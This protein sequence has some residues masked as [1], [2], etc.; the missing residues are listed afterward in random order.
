MWRPFI[1]GTVIAQCLTNGPYPGN[2]RL[3]ELLEVHDLLLLVGHYGVQF[4]QQLVLV[5]QPAFQ[6]DEALLILDAS[7]AAVHDA[8]GVG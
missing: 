1:A 6:V 5:R 4:V 3:A 2:Q 7:F 8:L